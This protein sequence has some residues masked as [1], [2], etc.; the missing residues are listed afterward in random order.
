MKIIRTDRELQTPHVD[1]TLRAAGHDARNIARL[2]P[3]GMIFI[4]CKDGISHNEAES[5]T[6]Q[7]CA[8]AA[9]VIADV[10]V[11]IAT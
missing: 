9:Q 1:A 10:L 6:K 2:G 8:A 5:A 3:A 11:E 4:P 7:D